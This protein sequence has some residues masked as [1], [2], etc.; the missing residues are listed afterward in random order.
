MQKFPRQLKN[1]NTRL[2]DKLQDI[3][4]A[5]FEAITSD[6][7]KDFESKIATTYQAS[8]LNKIPDFKIDTITEKVE[9]GIRTGTK[10]RNA[11][12]GSIL[13]GVVGFVVGGPPGAAA[14]SM[15]GGSLGGAT[16]NSA[17]IQYRDIEITVGDNL[18]DIRS[19]ILDAYCAQ[20]NSLLS[21]HCS[22]LWRDFDQS[23][24]TLLKQL[25]AAMAQFKSAL[26][27]ILHQTQ[28]SH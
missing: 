28:L 22:A 1:F 24:Q 16:G 10:K 12:I 19:S 4:N 27:K 25:N 9:T 6:L 2:Q 15:L 23:I 7:S 3:F 26:E 14:G 21:D 17:N 11:G 18:Q 20:L 5:C 8:T 13:G